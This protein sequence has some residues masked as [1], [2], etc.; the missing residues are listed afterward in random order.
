MTVTSVWERSI[1]SKPEPGKTIGP[2]TARLAGSSMLVRA[3]QFQ[4]AASPMLLV[5]GWRM[6]VVSE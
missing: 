6:T 4:K 5:F 3:A 1:D 2:R